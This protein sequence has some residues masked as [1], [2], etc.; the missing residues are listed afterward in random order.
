MT[1]GR[2]CG[3]DAGQED[4]SAGWN[5]ARLCI[6]LST[7]TWGCGLKAGVLFSLWSVL[8]S[9]I[10]LSGGAPSDPHK[11]AECVSSSCAT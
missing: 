5:P 1:A 11:G 3:E 8:L 9:A 4:A 7:W 6:Q 2:G 10:P